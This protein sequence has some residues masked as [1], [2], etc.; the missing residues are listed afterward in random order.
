LL[1]TLDTIVHTVHTWETQV[2]VK[3]D[4]VFLSQ[5]TLVKVKSMVTFDSECQPN[6][7]LTLQ[8]GNLPIDRLTDIVVM[9]L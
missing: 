8:L 1:D 4:F 7:T 5:A 3:Y 2:E 9:A 6:P